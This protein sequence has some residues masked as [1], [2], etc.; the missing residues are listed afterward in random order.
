MTQRQP[1]KIG[2]YALDE[3]IRRVRRKADFSQRELARWA[4][5]SA[6]TIAG[7]ESGTRTPSLALLQQVLHAANAQ[8]AVV[9]ASGHL[10]A[11]LQV[12][13]DVRDLAGRRFPAHLD[14]ILDPRPG[15]W[16]ADGFGL[17]RP[18]ETFRRNRVLRDYER[19]MSRWEVRVKQYRSAPAPR[20]PAN[21]RR[22]GDWRP[23]P[24]VE[25][26]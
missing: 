8:L 14:T 5:V 2:G 25:V 13:S 19:R 9:D 17:A 6:A 7:I 24:D 10:V 16:W 1:I 4:H 18:P 3:I 26:Q 12:W 22:G 21:W 15:E 11:P 20:L 23:D